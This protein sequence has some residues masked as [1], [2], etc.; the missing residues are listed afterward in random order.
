MRV[1]RRIFGVEKEEVTVKWRK[2]HVEEFH[3]LY[4]SF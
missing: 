1:F 4:T 2:L 3:V